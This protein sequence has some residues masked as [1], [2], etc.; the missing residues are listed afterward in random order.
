MYCCIIL[1]CFYTCFFGNTYV[2]FKITAAQHNRLATPRAVMDDLSILH[3]MREFVF[4][5]SV[6]TTYVVM[7]NEKLRLRVGAVRHLA[8]LQ[9]L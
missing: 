2:M 3:F 7:P 1:L 4:Q 9:V 6:L 8:E 5:C